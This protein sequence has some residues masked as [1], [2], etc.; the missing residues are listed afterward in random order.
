MHGDY[1]RGHEPDRKRGRSYRRVLLQMGRPLLDSDFASM[2]D[3]VLGE[4]RTATRGL[5]CAAGS[6]DLGFLV[7]PGRL[8]AVFAEAADALT[9]TQGTP[10]AWIDYRHRFLGR[11]PA[12]HLAATAGEARVTLPLL[13][14]LDPAGST[15]AL[16]ARAEA[17]TTIALNG[18]PVTVEPGSPEVPQRV[19]FTPAGTLDPL[20]IR[21]PAGEEVWLFL[22]EQAEAAGTDPAFWVA[23]GTY[24]VDGLVADARGGGAFPDVAFP[25]AAGYPWNA[26]PRVVPL[27]GLLAPAGLSP[28]D[29]LV[30][31]LEVWE[32]H[33]TAVEDPGIREEALGPTDTAARTELLGQVKLATV[34]GS[35][36][37]PTAKEL[38]AAFD[39]VSASGGELTVSV[40]QATPTTDPCA[41]PDV[42]GYSGSDN[43]LYR[44]EVHRSGSLSQVRL[45]WSR[46]NGSELFAARLDTSRNLVFDAGTKLAAGDVVEVLS[47]VVDLGDD[48]LAQVS[49]DDFVPAERA[50]GQLAQLAAVD[51]SSSSADEVAFGLVD[52]DDVTT[53]VSL[54]EDRYGTPLDQVLKLRRWH[55][56]LDPQQLAGGGTASIGPHVLEDGIAVTL[57]NTGSYR[58]GQW[59]QYEARVRD[60]NANGPWRPA[61][62]GPERRFAPLALLEY[63]GANEPLR[64]LAW[65]DERFSHPCD[66][67][68]D[69]VD[70][71]GGRIGSTSDTVQEVIEEIYERLPRVEH[72]PTVAA[73]GIS[74]SNDR[75]LPLA[76]LNQ[77]LRVTFSEEMHP[78]S[79]TPDTFVV[80]LEVPIVGTRPELRTSLVVDGRVVV[81][82]RTWTFVPAQLDANDI[83]RWTRQLRGPVRCRVRLLG[84]AILDRAGERPLDGD[85]VGNPRTEGYETFVDLRLPSGDGHR[86]GDFESWFYV[87]GPPPPVTVDHIDPPADTHFSPG[88]EPTT[89][90]LSFSDSVRFD[91]LTPKTLAVSVRHST[92]PP[93]GEGRPL[94]GKI[95]P[96][97]FEAEPRLVSRVTFAPS[98]PGAFRRLES[99]AEG[100]WIVTVRARGTGDEPIVDADGR[101]LDGAGTGEPSDFVSRFYIEPGH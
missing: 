24:H 86:G 51:A 26:S 69:D 7:T 46:D 77:G 43:R 96:Y 81:A 93:D 22:L 56:I 79:A 68:A 99:P 28:G 71:E 42:A 65:L 60:A 98:D 40:P 64:L 18:A 75:L 100:P 52:P 29:Q 21:V 74:W 44:I 9:V 92:E 73:N 27:H 23:P 59:W 50:V 101:A 34:V 2:V 8:L 70:F 57:S 31:Y 54:D 35:S 55:G 82:G 41:L 14:P 10:D 97:P 37:H 61:P 66:L 12:L 47:N 67:D 1:S 19:E 49:A 84:N 72:W 88:V 80:T 32:R 36:P 15:A 62:H 90:L 11:Y 95:Q 63:E 91:S 25:E 16:W 45:K 53:A 78:A 87:S 85:A 17:S 33:V 30:A 39:T 4:V 83:G 58:A 94:E 89:I 5:G 13:Q 76:E 48:A 20:E 6:P 3:A 38:R